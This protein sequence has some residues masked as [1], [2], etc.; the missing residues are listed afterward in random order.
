MFQLHVNA[1]NCQN[2]A[3]DW[4]KTVIAYRTDKPILLPVVDVAL[5]DL[6]TPEKKATI[7]IGDV[8]FS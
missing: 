5:R 6:G 2:R 1:S 4:K 7:E 3:N 8:C